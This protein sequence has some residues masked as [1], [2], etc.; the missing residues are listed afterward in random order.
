MNRPAL[1]IPLVLVVCVLGAI[2][3]TLLKLAISRAAGEGPAAT[4]AAL[5][6]DVVFWG[7]G[8]TVAAGALTWLYVM[9]RA[10]L[11]YAMPFLG[12]GFVLTMATSAI[13]LHEPQP[14]IRIVGTFVIAVG[15]VLVAWGR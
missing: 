11:T 14:T 6:R 13:V 10:H 4:V 9:S 1:V 8:L 12:M 3:Q 5:L 7:G 15:M 2:G